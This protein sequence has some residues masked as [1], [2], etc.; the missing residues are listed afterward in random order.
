[1]RQRIGNGV[2]CPLCSGLFFKELTPITGMQLLTNVRTRAVWRKVG[3]L[4]QP[5]AAPVGEHSATSFATFFCNKVAS[6]RETTMNAPQPTIHH[7]EVPPFR[8]FQEATT[9]EVLEIL[10]TASNKQCI[11]DPAPT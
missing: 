6:I 8:R 1:M 10:R 9:D 5:V 2:T 11:I 7:R 4:L 3:A